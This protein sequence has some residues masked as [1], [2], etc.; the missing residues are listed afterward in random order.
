MPSTAEAPPSKLRIPEEDNCRDA[1]FPLEARIERVV[2]SMSSQRGCPRGVL[3][4]HDSLIERWTDASFF[5]SDDFVCCIARGRFIQCSCAGT[6]QGE[7]SGPVQMEPCRS[8]PE[9]WRMENCGRQALRRYP[10][11]EDIPGNTELLPGTTPRLSRLREQ[12]RQRIRAALRLRR[13]ELRPGH[14]RFQVLSD[15]VGDESD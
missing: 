2:T 12:S 6:R 4:Q 7:D 8:L 5:S 13:D 14:E 10:R 9:R 1:S 11:S 15:E 3:D